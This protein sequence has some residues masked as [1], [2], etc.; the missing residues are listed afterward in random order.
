MTSEKWHLCDISLISDVSICNISLIDGRQHLC[1]IRLTSDTSL[2]KISLTSDIDFVT[3]VSLTSNRWHLG[4]IPSYLSLTSAIGLC[5]INLIDGRLIASSWHQSYIRHNISL[6]DGRQHLCD[7][8]LTS[9]TSLC[10]IS[11]TSDIKLCNI[12]L[13]DIRQMAS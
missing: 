11:L 2:W 10:N 7:I 13:I 1:D 5:N 8:S 9:D 4:G 6:I 12:C 3:S